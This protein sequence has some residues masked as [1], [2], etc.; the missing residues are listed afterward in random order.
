MVDNEKTDE[1]NVRLLQAVT[2][3]IEGHKAN[4]ALA[5][6]TPEEPGGAPWTF[7]SITDYVRTLCLFH[8]K[9]PH[10]PGRLTPDAE[11]AMKEALWLWTSKTSRF[12]DYG[13]EDLFL[14]LGTENHDLNICPVH[15]LLTSLLESD[16]NYRDSKLADGHTTAQHAA[17][18]KAFF[19]E[20]PRR[21]VSSGMWIE[22][23]SNFYQK[24]S[25]PALFNL[26]ELSP[27][28][29]IRH[30]FGLLLDLALVEEE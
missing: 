17:A 5:S 19:R 30:R 9:S 26:H 3:Y 4:G 13:T 12:A 27:D 7:F 25:W 24:Y 29:T 16:P 23:S 18:H 10:F 1:A 28:P 8:A 11:A 15:Y 22:V 6:P 14:L 20:W 21:R 2:R